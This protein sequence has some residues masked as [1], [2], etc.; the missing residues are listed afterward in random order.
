MSTTPKEPD[1]F[2]PLVEHFPDVLKAEADGWREFTEALGVTRQCETH[3][4]DN[5]C[6]IKA[7]LQLRAFRKYITAHKRAHAARRWHK[8]GKKKAALDYFKRLEI[9]FAPERFDHGGVRLAKKIAAMRA[10]AERDYQLLGLFNHYQ[11][12]LQ[13]KGPKPEVY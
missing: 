4:E 12:Y 2:R 6:N 8:R 3:D 1:I 7:C 10:E 13:G 5:P 9:A 11:E